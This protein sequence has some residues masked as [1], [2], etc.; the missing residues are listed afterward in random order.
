MATLYPTSSGQALN[1]MAPRLACD[2]ASRLARARAHSQSL[3]RAHSLP[4]MLCVALRMLMRDVR[5][6]SA[7]PRLPE[8]AAAGE[9][10]LGT[11]EVWVSGDV[12]G[13]G[14]GPL[15]V[16]VNPPRSMAICTC[17]DTRH[18]SGPPEGRHGA[19]AWRGTHGR[20]APRRGT[21]S[22]EAGGGRT[23]SLALP[24]TGAASTL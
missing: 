7:P 12:A 14:A 6:E 15:E 13:G 10:A 4:L 24:L 1:G 16:G 23:V 17:D 5:D 2:P 22:D 21:S 3:P 18:T 19:E 9:A 8:A 20:E 11:G